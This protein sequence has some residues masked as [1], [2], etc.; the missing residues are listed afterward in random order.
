MNILGNF[1]SFLPKENEVKTL[2]KKLNPNRT[3]VDL[4]ESY[5]SWYWNGKAIKELPEEY[6][7]HQSFIYLITNLKTGLRYVG[8]KMLVSP[9]SKVVESKKKRI[10]IESDWKS[11]CGSSKELL[12][13]VGIYGKK[14]FLR[15]IIAFTWNKTVGKYYE[16]YEQINRKVLT[17][18]A[19][20]YYNGIINVRLPK[21]TLKDFEKVVYCETLMGDKIAQKFFS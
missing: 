8:F 9:S 1:D 19:S 3:K 14:A 20:Q 2:D 10:L 7:D 6:K 5:N 12:N 13:D 4:K 17:D 18:N 15:E 11:Y 21:Q 16:C